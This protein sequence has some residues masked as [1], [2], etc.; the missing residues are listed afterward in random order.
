MLIS[1]KTT[2]LHELVGQVQ[3]VV[4][5]LY[6]CFLHKII[7]ESIVSLATNVHEKTSKNITESQDTKFESMQAQFIICTHLCYMRM[8][9]FSANEKWIIF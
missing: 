9:S 4:W 1:T 7:R 5:K 2:K 3:F 8:H 6:K